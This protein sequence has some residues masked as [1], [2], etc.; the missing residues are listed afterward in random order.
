MGDLLIMEN[1]IP[2]YLKPYFTI[3]KTPK[4]LNDK[5]IVIGNIRCSCG[6]ENF[7]VIRDKWEQSPESKMAEKQIKALYA[8]YLP[9]YKGSLCEIGSDDG[10][11]WIALSIYPPTGGHKMKYLE[12]ITELIE[13][14]FFG[15]PLTPTFLEAICS[16]CGQKILI[17][18]SSRYGYDALA[19]IAEKN[20]IRKYATDFKI[21]KKQKCRKCGNETSKIIIEISSTGKDDLFSESVA[22]INDNNWEDAF[23]WITVDLKCGGCGKD[24]KK[25]LDLETM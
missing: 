11:R 18:D 10:R 1:G 24:T 15:E 8:K 6:T 16:H 12:D 3:T 23:D 22:F 20:Y 7:T 2:N 14:A 17:Y 25:Y 21:V 4:T 9:Q 13:I 5:F 19:I